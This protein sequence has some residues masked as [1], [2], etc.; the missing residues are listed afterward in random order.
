MINSNQTYPYYTLR[1]IFCTFIF[2]SSYSWANLISVSTHYTNSKTGQ[3]KEVTG[4]GFWVG[5]DC[6]DNSKDLS[7]YNYNPAEYN[8]CKKNLVITAAHLAQGS[9]TTL[10]LSTYQSNQNKKENIIKLGD[11]SNS[12]IDNW[13]DLQIFEIEKN[14]PALNKLQPLFRCSSMRT[15]YDDM[16]MCYNLFL[17]NEDYVKLLPNSKNQDTLFHFRNFTYIKSGID[18]SI[19][20]T[21]SFVSLVRPEQFDSDNILL[22]SKDQINR[23]Y[24]WTFKNDKLILPNTIYPGMSGTPL[25]MQS[26]KYEETPDHFTR[27]LVGVGIQTDCDFQES[28]Y[29]SHAPI[30]R[31]INKY[32]KNDQQ[33]DSIPTPQWDYSNQ[34]YRILKT[35]KFTLTEIDPKKINTDGT[36]GDVHDSLN[37]KCA[38]DE[39]RYTTDLYLQ[40]GDKSHLLLGFNLKGL[41]SNKQDTSFIK[42]LF[43]TRDN[44]DVLSGAVWADIPSIP[45]ILEQSNNTLESLRERFILD[46][47]TLDLSDL[48]KSKL[49]ISET[50]IDQPV[51][52]SKLDQC[53]ITIQENSKFIVKINSSKLSDSALEFEL[54]KNGSLD[55]QFQSRFKIESKNNV[56]YLIDIRQLF[57]TDLHEIQSHTED[58]FSNSPSLA[59]IIK[60]DGAKIKIRNLKSTSANDTF[61]FLCRKSTIGEL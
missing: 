22:N 25:L 50:Q 43:K 8:S 59:A 44:E 45:H 42:S 7:S 39:K 9:N 37:S 41:V 27:F 61:T 60:N 21:L 49:N 29:V 13:N 40:E 6:S 3:I 58:G 47:E 34:T 57:F 52:S 1:S 16:I 38:T 53:F 2:L 51:N 4:T 55:T 33:S 56:P 23:P 19:W 20:N 48:L 24:R 36:R 32:L 10:R 26:E 14:D 15:F 31:L 28:V 30:S 12:F 18:D 35:N 11:K 5:L 17:I 46:N 54:N